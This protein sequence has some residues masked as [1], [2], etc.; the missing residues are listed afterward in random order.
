MEKVREDIF[1]KVKKQSVIV[2]GTNGGNGHPSLRFVMV[3]SYSPEGELWVATGAGS[4]KSAEIKRDPRVTVL[5]SDFEE[6]HNFYLE[7]S[8]EVIDDPETKTKMWHDNWLHFWPEG[9]VSEEYVLLRIIPLRGES[10]DNE[11]KEPVKV[12][13]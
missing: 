10:F 2:L 3:I 1:R 6:W 7:C 5:W 13:F 8:A 9:P 4:R 11:K 12:E